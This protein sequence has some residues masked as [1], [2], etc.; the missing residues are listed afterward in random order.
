MSEMS[1]AARS[2]VEERTERFESRHGLAESQ[3]RLA[4]SLARIAGAGAT[5]FT[6]TWSEA[7][8]RAVLQARFAPPAR[9]LRILKVIS[10]AMLLAVAMSAWAIA[11]QE[12]PLQFVLPLFTF[13]AVLALPFV[14]LGLASQRDAVEARLRRAI[15]VALLDEEERMPPQQ[16][17]EDED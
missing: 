11:T 14:A 12:G 9:T 5:V 8:G 10:V 3:S 6:S 2:L 13:L 17:W 16:R 15:R 4:A 7:D 1:K